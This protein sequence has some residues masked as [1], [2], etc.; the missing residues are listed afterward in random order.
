MENAAAMKAEGRA[1]GADPQMANATCHQVPLSFLR[2]GEEA[3]VVKVRG[4]EELQRHLE[5]LG[6]VPGAQIKAV[7][8]ASGNMIVEVKGAQVALSQ[9]VAMKVITSASV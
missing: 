3:Q 6:F 5:T 1:M 2:S 7:S 8:Q 9:Q 4:K